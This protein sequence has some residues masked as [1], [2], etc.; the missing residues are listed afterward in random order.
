MPVWRRTR[1][2]P[3]VTKISLAPHQPHFS[4]D[5]RY[6]SFSI[7]ISVLAG[8]FWWEG[9]T[10]VRKG[11]GTIRIPPIDLNSN[12][13][14]KLVRALGPA[15]LR[16][17]G[18]EADKIHYLEAQPES[19]DALI[20]TASMW[21]SLHAFVE[22]NQLKLCF[23]FKYG[24]FKRKHHG[25]WHGSEVER[26]LHHSKQKGY[27]LD[28]CELGNELNAYW[29]FHGLSAQ[30]SAKN[31]ADDYQ[32]FSELVKY[33]YPEARIIGP[34]SAFW[35]LLGETI[36][37]FSNLTRR[38]LMGCNQNGAK[39]DLVDW[40]YYPFQSERAPVSTRRA[41]LNRFLSPRVLNDFARYAK[42]IKQYRDHFFPDAELWLGETGSAQCG[43]QPK[44]SDRFASS[45]WYVDQ[46]GL[47]ALTGHSVVVRQSLVGGDYGLVN[48]LT[49]KPRPDYWVAWLWKQ[50]MGTRVYHV[51]APHRFIRA[52]CHSTPQ[53]I[54]ESAVT[55]VLINLAS[56]PVQLDYSE[57]GE[58]QQQYCV[59]AKRL[60]SKRIRINGI[61]AR[62]KGGKF[63]L[64]DFDVPQ[65][66]FTPICPGYSINF[67]V[68]TTPPDFA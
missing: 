13:L 61:K 7:D 62:F 45:F 21:D 63:T 53:L 17:G 32:R 46:L 3:V 36:K 67:W 2:H 52:Y 68:L 66:E 10:G 6:L 28:V 12:K 25:F 38:F 11:L 44:L 43:G 31:L 39:L 27:K 48:R 57:L 40:H 55:L 30:P 24:L 42:Q 26:L 5:T 19:L 41:T 8:G 22:R 23:T 16:I 51:I 20:L 47:A 9:S 64:A 56:R 65:S 33:H 18:S 54:A 34:G 58:I 15:Y 60:A 35:P 50:L 14:D 49:L 1:L 29:A 4:V 59:T 37:P